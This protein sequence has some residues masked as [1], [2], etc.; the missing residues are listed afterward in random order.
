MF[1]VVVVV[2]PVVCN[3]GGAGCRP[4]LSHFQLKKAPTLFQPHLNFGVHVGL[5]MMLESMSGWLLV[6]DRESEISRNQ[7][8]IQK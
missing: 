6:R 1:S 3:S 8:E 4:K 5:M 2:V 7:S